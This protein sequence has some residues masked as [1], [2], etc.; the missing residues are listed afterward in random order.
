MQQAIDIAIEAGNVL[1]SYFKSADIQHVIKS[2]G[3][4]V[5][6]AD[7]ASSNFLITQLTRINPDTPVLSEENIEDFASRYKTIPDKCWIV[8]PLDGT[9]LFLHGHSG[10]MVLMAYLEN[11]KPVKAIAHFPAREETFF[12]EAGKGSF[13]IEKDGHIRKLWREGKP[14]KA[15]PLRQFNISL[16]DDSICF[17][18]SDAFAKASG[19]PGVIVSD[20]PED[21]HSYLAIAEGLGDICARYIN[22]PYRDKN[23]GGGVW[24]HAALDLILSEANCLHVTPQGSPFLY[25]NPKSISQASL[26]LAPGLDKD[27]MARIFD[28][29]LREHGLPAPITLNSMLF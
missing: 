12:A 29:K 11:Q 28:E 4:D 1:M 21:P 8:D 25:Q 19:Y 13:K 5:T 26:T 27:Q 24:D 6:A 17:E 7:D 23:A 18:I 22:K 9:R 15:K 3:S 10:F 16:Y 14:D 20:T 2:D